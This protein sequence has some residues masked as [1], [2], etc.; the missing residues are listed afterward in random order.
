MD[1]LVLRSGLAIHPL[2][3]AIS[4]GPILAGIIVRESRRRSS[5]EIE[6]LVVIPS[7]R[8]VVWLRYFSRRRR[9]DR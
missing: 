9:F 3:P 4:F 6:L 1:F 2:S 8:Q 5:L 7:L